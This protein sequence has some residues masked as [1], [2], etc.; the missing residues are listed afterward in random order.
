MRCLIDTNI[1]IDILDRGEEELYIKI[2][3]KY[4]DIKISWVTLYEYLLGIALI[5][6][7][8]AERK[9]EIEE[10]F[11]VIYPTQ[12]DIIETINLETELRKK[13]IKI[14]DRDLLIAGQARSRGL[15]IITK[16][17][18]HFKLLKQYNIKTHIIKTP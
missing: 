9:K 1:L 5:N 11:E 17:E 18:K 7:D 13:G 3:T 6:E 15:T 12:Q 2:A 4:P 14:P 8:T 16:D 10:I